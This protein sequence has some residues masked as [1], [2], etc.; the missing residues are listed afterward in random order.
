MIK[1]IFKMILIILLFVIAFFF[2]GNPPKPEKIIWGIN[3]S[4]KHAQN[5]GIDWKESYSALI[6]ELGVRNI[7]LA[8][9]WDLIEPRQGEYD[10]SD[11]DWQIKKAEEKEVNIVPIIGMKVPRWPECHVPQW[12]KNLS[13]E[14]QQKEISGMLKEI[15]ERYKGSPSI[16]QW[17]VENEPLFSFGECQWIDKD[18][19][20]K[21]IDLVK[22]LDEQKRPIIISD[23]GEGSFWIE[24]A[25]LG[26]IVGTTIYRKVWMSQLNNYLTY[27][28]PPIFY[29]RKAEIVKA[30]FNKKVI[31]IELQAEP[32]GPKLLYDS[33]LEEQEKTMNLTQFQKNI[34]FAKKTGFD[35]FYLWG[36]EW[37]YWMKEKQ[38]NPEIWDEAGKL[39]KN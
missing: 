10:F 27:R 9:H 36:G 22:S 31:C 7:K 19:L 37:W 14:D 34:E 39:F 13:K 23:S 32:W 17:Q 25:K 30:L 2:I 11:L 20:K 12:A 1:N 24:A 38:N 6:D 21:E 18:F 5:L 16:K 26:D 3:F 4:Q 8:V 35:E 29:W 33:S 28:F 15:I